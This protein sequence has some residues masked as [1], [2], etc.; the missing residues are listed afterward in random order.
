MQHRKVRAARADHLHKTA[1][2]LV[3]DNQAVYVEDLN[4]AGMIRRLARTG[5]G[6]AGCVPPN[7]ARVKA[8]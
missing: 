7:G 6:P 4:T 5:P 8:D 3:R 2:R 1:L